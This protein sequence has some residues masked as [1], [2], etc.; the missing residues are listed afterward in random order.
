MLL[1]LSPRNGFLSLSASSGSFWKFSMSTVCVFIKSIKI[2]RNCSRMWRGSMDWESGAGTCG[3]MILKDSAVPDS[4]MFCCA[5]LN[6]NWRSRRKLN[7]SKVSVQLGKAYGSASIWLR[8]LLMLGISLEFMQYP[9]FYI[10]WRGKWS[11]GLCWAMLWSEFAHTES[12][13]FTSDFKHLVRKQ[14]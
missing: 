2:Y 5:L 10:L 7:V 1:H 3:S 8:N 12:A 6:W 14:M 9:Y 13:N 4:R 11:L